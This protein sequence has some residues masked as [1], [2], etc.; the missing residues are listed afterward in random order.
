MSLLLS[1]ILYMVSR[2]F[3]V[4]AGPHRD[5]PSIILR[6]FPAYSKD[7]CPEKSQI[8]K[9]KWVSQIGYPRNYTHFILEF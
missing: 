6:T 7:L 9:T 4:Y 8:L 1:K 5:L 2:L 3:G